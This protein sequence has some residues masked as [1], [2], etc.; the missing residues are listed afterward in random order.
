[1]TL[2]EIVSRVGKREI[3]KRL[4]I[5]LK[6]LEIWLRKGPSLSGSIKIAKLIVR[7]LRSKKS[8]ETRIAVKAESGRS[9]FNT[10]AQP[11]A[12]PDN[13]Y[14]VNLTDD[15]VLPVKTP[16]EERGF[17]SLIKQEGIEIGNVV[18]IESA[19]RKG[20]TRW[21]TIGKPVLEIEANE[22]YEKANSYWQMSGR[23]HVRIVF[24]YFRYIPF[25]PIYTGEM[26]SKQGKW[27]HGYLSTQTWPVFD[28]VIRDTNSVI[29][30]LHTWAE[31]RLIWLE[32][33]GIETIDER[34][35]PIL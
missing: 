10:P 4:G 24:L 30:D 23:T 11:T 5:S 21:I 7:H 15:E 29:F 27:A 16:A 31:S 25:N 22:I 26:I 9:R 1:M 32:S 34:M 12:I 14:S 17:K 19:Y 6:T 33:I 3:A 18:P 8:A 13:A 20:E 28:D 35:E 2:L